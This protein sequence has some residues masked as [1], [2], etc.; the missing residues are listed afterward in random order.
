[1]ERLGE[2]IVSALTP[3]EI[4]NI[5]LFGIRIS[6]TDTVISMWIAMALIIGVVIFLTRSFKTIPEGRQNVV[7]IAVEFI[8]NFTQDTIGHH[9]KTFAPFIGTLLFFLVTANII[10]IFNFIPTGETL[11]RITGN[12]PFANWPKY[13]IRPPAKDVN[14]PFALAT[15][16]TFFIIYGAIK[17]KK[18]SGW[19]KSFV[20]PIPILLPLNIMEYFIRILSLSF[21]LFGNILGAF[22]IMELI[23]MVV[24][25]ALP[26]ALSIY[27]DLFDG[28]LQA[29]IFV[30]LS[31]FY[32]AEAVE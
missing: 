18:V 11:Y 19:L 24:P 31:T 28:A 20:Q 12:E 5:N 6:I 16:T 25:L 30:Y 7:E 32:I 23:Y 2:E 26:A 10:S 17:F 3:T 15:V 4:F 13:S 29:Y 27:F 14:V 1:M 9:W 8:N 21:R 22:I